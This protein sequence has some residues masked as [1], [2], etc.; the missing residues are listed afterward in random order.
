MIKSYNNNL[1]KNNYLMTKNYR[2]KGLGIIF[3]NKQDKNY[4]S[5][6]YYNSMNCELCNKEYKCTRDR[7]LDHNH[8]N[9]EPRNVICN[10]CNSMR[11]DRKTNKNNK[12]S[13][14]IYYNKKIDKYIFDKKLENIRI[15]K[16]NINLNNLKWIKFSI[17]LLHKD[18][19][20]T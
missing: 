12:Y 15:I 20:F 13:K 10:R 3:K 4:W 11:S 6:R 18:K 16:R 14:N 17:L 1:D 9:G 7:Q 5:N 8:S 19:L 2:W